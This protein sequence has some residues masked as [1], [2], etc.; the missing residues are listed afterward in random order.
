MRWI[1]ILVAIALGL[2]GCTTCNHRA[3]DIALE[4]DRC[5]D[6]DPG[7][8]V[9][10]YAVVVKG[11]DP[12]DL[13][14]TESLIASLVDAGFPKVYRIENHHTSFVEREVQQ[15][16]SDRPDARFVVIGS[17]TGAG[18]ARQLVGRVSSLGGAVDALIEVAPVHPRF[19]GA[20]YAIPESIRHQIIM[21]N[22]NTY[23]AAGV[24]TEYRIVSDLGIWS[25]CVHPEV[26]ATIK[27][28]MV[29]SARGIVPEEASTTVSMP[30]LDRPA[31]LPGQRKIQVEENARIPTDSSARLP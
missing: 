12:L 1:W 21:R 13:A 2:P 8:R 22:G 7:Q 24:A 10:V 23:P 16:L 31:P 19:L 15:I 9:H 20:S 4:S 26:T 3:G 25:P 14:G 27:D 11:F 29:V 17:G 6:V 18:L 28:A 30:L 5:P